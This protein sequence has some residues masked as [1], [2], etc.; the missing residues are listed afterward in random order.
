MDWYL[1][2]SLAVLRSEVDQR[3]PARSKASDG[4]IGDTAH[5]ARTSDHNPNSRGAVD[6]I[7]VTASGV[8]VPT[9]ITA[10]QRHPSAH[11]WIWQRQ[12]ADADDGWRPRAYTGT[13]PHDHHIHI[14]IRQSATAEQD[15]RPWGLLTPPDEPEEIPPMIRIKAKDNPA[16]YLSN[17]AHIPSMDVDGA[18]AAAGV[19]LVEV[20]TSA[21]LMALLPAAQ[22]PDP[23]P[24]PV[25][26][27]DYDRLAEALLRRI[28]TG[29]GGG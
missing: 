4:T 15:R 24:V 14:S 16:R 10:V 1:A 13:N 28:A 8:H 2:P 29:G 19:P 18:L 7:D 5:Q 9:I 25:P 17:G 27:L 21:D 22:A 11:Y 6:A 23:V 20:A 26:V 12:I 3:W